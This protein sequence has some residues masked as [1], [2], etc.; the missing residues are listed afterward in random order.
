VAVV[1][2]EEDTGVEEAAVEEE[3]EIGIEWH[4]RQQRRPA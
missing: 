1:A 2:A 3:E 4:R